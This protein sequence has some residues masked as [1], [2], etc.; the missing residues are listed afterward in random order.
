METGLGP[1]SGGTPSR[2][3]LFYPDK[4]PLGWSRRQWT[5]PRMGHHAL[6]S[7]DLGDRPVGR[8]C[9]AHARIVATRGSGPYESSGEQ[10]SAGCLDRQLAHWA[11]A[12]G[13]QVKLLRGRPGEIPM[14]WGVFQHVITLPPE[15]DGW[16]AYALRTVLRHELGHVARRD[17]LW[18]TC[19]RV[20]LLACWFHPLAWWLLKELARSAEHA[21][22]D[23]ATASISGRAA[24]ARNLVQ[25]VSRC[26][27]PG[28]FGLTSPFR[29]A[30][31]MARSSALR[32][33]VEALME[34]QRD[35][36][37][38]RRA[39]LKWQAPACALLVLALGSF[40]ACKQENRVETVEPPVPAAASP[41]AQTMAWMQV[42]PGS[43]T[44]PAFIVC[45]KS[46]GGCCSLVLRETI[47]RASIPSRAHPPLSLPRRF[48]RKLW[49]GMPPQLVST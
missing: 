36:A 43:P 15:A 16:P 30:L 10:P 45:R 23:L 2:A 27:T 33:R 21:S 1:L 14:T 28:R 49:R 24:Y 12:P 9:L 35:R 26:H 39:L 8:C 19:A 22:D 18:L 25:V 31:A 20:C 3:W 32:R 7:G 6:L 37:P 5:R 38:Y 44:R 11:W 29:L 42:L 40:T 17:F 47:P 46:C 34:H 13:F 48:M 41:A 4:P